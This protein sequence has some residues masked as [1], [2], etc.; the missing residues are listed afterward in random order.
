MCYCVL[1]QSASPILYIADITSSFFDD[2]TSS[3]CLF[4]YKDYT[5][6]QDNSH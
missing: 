3:F 5:L 1:M 6:Y 4:F 2:I